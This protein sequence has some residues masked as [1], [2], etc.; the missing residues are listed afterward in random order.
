MLRRYITWGT[1]LAGLAVILGAFGA[2]KLKELATPELV[3]GFQTGVQYQM[4]HSLALIL[5][6]IASQSNNTK[7]FRWSGTCFLLG[8]LL[9][10]GSIYLLTAIK[11]SEAVGVRGIGFITPIGGVF[12]IAGWL[13]FFIGSIAKPRS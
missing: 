12:F 5:L 6:A 10:S 13:F 7:F 3:A 8:I 11:A 2:H 1:A 4:Y 9:F